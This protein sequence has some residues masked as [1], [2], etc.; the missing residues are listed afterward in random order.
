MQGRLCAEER[1]ALFELEAKEKMIM[2]CLRKNEMIMSLVGFR[3]DCLS[4]HQ[5]KMNIPEPSEVGFR[6]DRQGININMLIPSLILICQLLDVRIRCLDSLGCCS[7][8]LSLD[9]CCFSDGGYGWQ[10]NN[11]ILLRAGLG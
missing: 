4:V 9:R 3:M 1:I 6:K 7:K 10:E 11:E 2:S 5:A 8:L